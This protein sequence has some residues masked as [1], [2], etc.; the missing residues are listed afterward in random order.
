MGRLIGRFLPALACL[1]VA[2]CGGGGSGGGG[3][4]EPPD[5]ALSTS[6][7]SFSSVQNGSAPASQSFTVTATGGT[8]GSATGTIYI[9]AGVSGIAVSSANITNCSTTS[10][11]VT[12]TPATNLS[13]GTYS[14]TVTI[15]GCTN[16]QC[17]T[18]VG[19]PKSVAVTYVVSPGPQLTSPADLVFLTPAGTQPAAQTL[20]L[21]SSVTGVAWTATVTYQ[22]GGSG[23]LSIPSSGEGTTAISVQPSAA[24]SGSYRA[25]INF[26]PTGGGSPTSTE[27][28]LFLSSSSSAA[29]GVTFVSPYV[30]P[31]GSS[32]EVT[33]RGGGFSTLSSPVVMFGTTAGTSVQLVSDSEIR[34]VNPALPAGQYPVTVSSGGQTMAGS[35]TFVVV[36]PPQ[37]PYAAIPLDSSNLNGLPYG[38]LIYDAERQAVYILD[39]SEFIPMQDS[40]ERFRYVSGA[41]VADPPI[42]FPLPSGGGFDTFAAIALTPDGGELIKSNL[43]TLSIIDLATWQVVATAD[44]T[45]AVGSDVYLMTGAMS[46]DGGFIELASTGDGSPAE[47]NEIIRYDAVANAFNVVA[48]P[49]DL[50]A[51]ASYVAAPSP[52]GEQVTFYSDATNSQNIFNYDAGSGAVSESSPPYSNINFVSYSRDGTRTLLQ[53]DHSGAVLIASATT[54]GVPAGTYP[55]VSMDAAVLSPDGTRIYYYDESTGTIHTLDAT[56]LANGTFPETGSPV[57]IP[58]SP[59]TWPTMVITPDGGNLMLAGTTNLIVIPTP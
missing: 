32:A 35:P 25:A 15:S 38:R 24:A 13:A 12:V 8:W 27:I 56:T 29:N 36:D 48:A 52:E 58:D 46:N 51:P 16:F 34:V 33:I 28:F 40:L 37:F 59:G 1:A 31:A 10:C 23:W 47:V 57:Q 18:P 54:A 26:V 22:A 21:Q 30:A 43:Q 55:L 4:N 3:S 5:F 20:N 53:L 41:W 44:A 17:A 49:V 9:S 45:S 2:A 39:N 42:N 7:L 14:A 50:T 19:T 11:Q 6:Q